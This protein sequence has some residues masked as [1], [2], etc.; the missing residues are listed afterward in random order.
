V[1]L[2][3]G[4]WAAPGDE[5]IL[6]LEEARPL[7]EQAVRQAARQPQAANRSLEQARAILRRAREQ[8]APGPFAAAAQDPE[9][10]LNEALKAADGSVKEAL[11]RQ[12]RD[13]VA[14]LGAVIRWPEA[15]IQ[16]GEAK[17]VL[18]QVLA[19][20]EFQGAGEDAFSRWLNRTLRRFL[21]F[22]ERLFPSMQ[23]SGKAARVVMWI[24]GLLLF[25]LLVF[26][27]A[28]GLANLLRYLSLR[29]TQEREGEGGG[30]V[31][32]PGERPTPEG[33]LAEAERQAGA[34]AYREALRL[35]YQA[36]LFLLDRRQLVEFDETRTNGEYERTLRE[37]PDPWWADRFAGATDLFERKWYGRQP[38]SAPDYRS[39]LDYCQ[40]VAGR[41][42]P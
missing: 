2:G 22:L 42:E 9:G 10:T 38:A 18:K 12:G 26:L 7:L 8:A 27:V 21:D 11:A 13:Q 3:G 32:R 28:Y 33:L 39:L 29:S 34:G 4:A 23:G 35:V 25:A 20:Q 41:A 15:S 6:A 40:E 31:T 17:E 5:W 19:S 37:R 36:V 1:L 16:R 30:V 24:V 14:S